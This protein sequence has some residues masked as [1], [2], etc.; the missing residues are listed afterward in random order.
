MVCAVAQL[1]VS[2][3]TC[4]HTVHCCNILIKR[5]STTGSMIMSILLVEWSSLYSV[6]ALWAAAE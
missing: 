1:E 6:P 4:N 5:G 2:L 3:K